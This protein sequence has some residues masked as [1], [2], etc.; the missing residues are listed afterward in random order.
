MPKK[1]I[2]KTNPKM[3]ETKTKKAVKVI[4]KMRSVSAPVAPA[5]PAA[6]TKKKIVFNYILLVKIL[7][8]IAIGA[9]VFLLVQK[10]RGLFIA[11]TV[12]KSPI[13][14]W[15]LNTRMAEKYGEQTLETIISERLLADNLKKYNV[16][17]TDQEINDELAKIKE[18]YGGEDQFKAAIAQYGM[19]EA[20]ASESIKQSIGLK[21]IIE[22]VYKIEIKDA[23]I[24]TYYNEN[25]DSF[26]GKKLE[27]VS[28]EIKDSL[29]QQE[30]YTKSQ[31]WYSQIRKA[32][33]VNSFI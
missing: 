33:S 25:K 14:R 31:E 21:K 2:K 5:T 10:N 19:T 6:V 24:Q 28:A 22:V 12:N 20:Q 26:S 29:Y 11:G 8:V 30:I 18:Q 15:E 16:V 9:V 13:T 1:T 4:K 17:I 27:E 32:A 3:S 23:D 7:L